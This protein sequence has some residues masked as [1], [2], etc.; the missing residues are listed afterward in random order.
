[1]FPKTVTTMRD[2]DFTCGSSSNAAAIVVHGDLAVLEA[3][4]PSAG[5]QP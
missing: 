3:N 2:T 5:K 1:M 4:Q